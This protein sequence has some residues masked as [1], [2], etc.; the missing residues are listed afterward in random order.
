MHDWDSS[1]HSVSVAS[2]RTE[3]PPVAHPHLYT[4]IPSRLYA[5]TAAT[6]NGSIAASGYGHYSDHS[7]LTS[8]TAWSSKGVAAAPLIGRGLGKPLPGS[9][10]HSLD[11]VASRLMQS[12]V[13][14]ANSRRDSL[15]LREELLTSPEEVERIAFEERRKRSQSLGI[16][17]TNRLLRP[18]L[19]H[20][21]ER[22]EKRAHCEDDIIVTSLNT[23]YRRRSSMQ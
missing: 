21:L 18:T 22:T 1:A 7:S 5:P 14:N 20:E 12:T 3:P 13:N 16:Q 4:H 6:S 2:V 17:P 8:A 11:H 9:K 19:G 15:R 10:D 23:F